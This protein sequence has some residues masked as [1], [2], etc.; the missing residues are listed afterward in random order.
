MR[1][2]FNT[3]YALVKES[4]KEEPL[5]GHVFV[6]CNR[7]RDLLKALYWDG[8]GLWISAKRLERG[9]FQWPAS[10]ARSSKLEVD[11][12]QLQALLGGIDVES[13]KR[14]NWIRHKST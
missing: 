7:R 12:S 2:S 13:H 9:T 11:W 1:K 4:L 5:E 6:F 14:R 3:L 10:D 8:S